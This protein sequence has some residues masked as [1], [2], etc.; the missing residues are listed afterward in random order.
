MRKHVYALPSPMLFITEA[1]L[2]TE[3]F[4]IKLLHVSVDES[5]I[6][7]TACATR[8][9]LYR[10]CKRWISEGVNGHKYANWSN[11]IWD[12]RAILRDCA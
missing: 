11:S 10:D 1:M 4:S 3:D 12:A 5:V 8:K 7:V 6:A 2:I 9:A